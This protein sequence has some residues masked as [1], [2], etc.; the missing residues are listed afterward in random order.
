VNPAVAARGREVRR[1]AS[2]ATLLMEPR[3][4][5]ATAAAVWRIEVGS[6]DEPA[7][8]AGISHALEHLA[9][10]GFGELDAAALNRRLD[11]LG[12]RANAYT[13]EDRTAFYGTVLPE[14]LDAF[15]AL[16]GGMLRPTLREEDVAVERRVILEEIAMAHDDPEGRAADAAAAAAFGAHPLGRPI[17]GSAA[18]VAALRP[19]DLRRW[20][21]VRY[22]PEALTVAVAGRFDAA[23]V[24]DRVEARTAALGEA[25]PAEG[26]PRRP[27]AW[28]PGTHRHADRRLRRAYGAL[29]APGAPQ[30]AEART[31]AALLA[32]VLGEPGHGALHWALVDPGLADQA[33][34]EHD[35]G[36][37]VGAFA[38]WLETA[39]EREDEARERF[40]AQLRGAQDRP[41]DPEAWER[42]ART[43]ATDL[44]LQA[45][46]P[47]GRAMALADGWAERREL[48]DPRAGIE[49]VLQAPPAAGAALLEERPFDRAT[50]VV[51]GPP[52]EGGAA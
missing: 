49:R 21:R 46:T 5:A 34:L 19:D 52:R 50:L 25:A 44:A 8:W 24:A 37:G 16:L 17:L 11:E 27:P 41:V 14:R 36:D 1:L 38:G 3:P 31:A 33:G 23:A 10:K 40:L 28:H 51:L 18:S 47:L 20:A 29:L 13:A 39:A 35:P 42:A 45:E 48:D 26:V 15:Q 30:D 6:R 22:R 32:Q 9:F 4:E 12:A 2:G 43:L 7:P